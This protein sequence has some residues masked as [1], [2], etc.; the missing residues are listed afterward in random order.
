MIGLRTRRWLGQEAPQL[1]YSVQVVDVRGV[2]VPNVEV[3]FGYMGVAEGMQRATT[4]VGGEAEFVV[5]EYYAGSLVAVGV[6]NPLWIAKEG[7]RLYKDL[8]EIPRD[9]T[10]VA[11]RRPTV[12][13]IKTNT[14]A[15]LV[16]MG[17]G[18][19]GAGVGFY[20]KKLMLGIPAILLG[21]TGLVVTISALTQTPVKPE[22]L[23]EV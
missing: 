16:T 22:D 15:G 18:A 3:M 10:L 12:Q 11:R 19:L 6:D 14:V 1:R 4:N 17:V 5:P 9:V 8:T 23:Q 2:P 21:F 7:A 13:S 20:Q